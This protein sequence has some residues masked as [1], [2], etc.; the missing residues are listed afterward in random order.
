MARERV[1]Q[2]DR[3]RVRIRTMSRERTSSPSAPLHPLSISPSPLVTDVCPQEGGGSKPS[4]QLGLAVIVGQKG[5]PKVVMVV[6]SSRSL[7]GMIVRGS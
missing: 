4:L 2:R 6:R 7:V 5:V 3:H 1:S